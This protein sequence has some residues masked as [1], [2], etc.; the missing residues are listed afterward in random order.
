MVMTRLRS[1]HAWSGTIAIASA[2][3]ACSHEVDHF[4]GYQSSQPVVGTIGSG[5]LDDGDDDGGESEGS[6][7]DGS[8]GD[9][10][11]EGAPASEAGD[12][13]DPAPASDDGDGSDEGGA[14]AETGSGDP[15]LDACLEIATNDC[16]SCA[17]NSCLDP[18]YACQQ[19]AGC[20]AM[21]DCAEQSGCVGADCLEP[22]GA[23]IDMYG[24]PFGSS[25]AL[26]LALSDCL[27][28]SCPVCF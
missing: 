12:D 23:V 25:G 16:E 15:V 10:A 1:A 24:G 4:H 13:A 27:S 3:G 2:L 14:P 11:G 21:R 5:N 7:S 22:C 28:A 18:L 6:S 26:A 19:D 9:D 20:V 17:C 8:E